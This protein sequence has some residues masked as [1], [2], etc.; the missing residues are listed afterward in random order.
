MP[1]RVLIV[2]YN[3][4]PVG[5]IGRVRTTKFA[6]Y[7]PSH[8]WSPTVLTVKKDRTKLGGGNLSEGDIPGV[9]VM[10]ASFPDPLTACQELLAGTESGIVRSP[11]VDGELPGSTGTASGKRKSAV[12]ALFRWAMS[13]AA[14]PDRYQLWFPFAV[15]KGLREIRRGGYDAIFSTSPPFMDHM[16]A[17]ALHALSGI[18]WMADYRDPWSQN[19]IM[20]FTPAKLRAAR[21]L[22]RAVLAG[23]HSITA[24]TP[25]M[26]QVLATLHGERPGGISCIPSGYDAD[27]YLPDVQVPGDQFVI[28]FTG[29]TYGLLMNPTSVIETIED[30]IAEDAIG[31]GDVTLRFYGPDACQL[32]TL[33]ENMRYPEILKLEG[34]V[35]REEAILRQQES[36]VLLTILY[37]DPYCAILYGG[38]LMEYLGTRRPILAW[39]PAGGAVTELLEETGAGASARNL[40]ELRAILSGWFDEYARTGAVSNRGREQVISRYGWEVLSGE[41]AVALEQMVTGPKGPDGRTAT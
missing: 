10:R 12:G 15:I 16:V 34:V 31:A 4:P 32:E 18:P 33:K 11:G 1:R 13:W 29:R 22:E 28:T 3:Y 21:W 2:S 38:K 8:G 23:A 17:A 14:F 30:L 39:T 27:D 26:A 20:T 40:P 7:L 37:D 6:K 24:T 9:K 35:P 25:Q 5:G 41:L 36:T 19:S